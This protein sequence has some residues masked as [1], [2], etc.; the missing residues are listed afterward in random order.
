[1]SKG[2]PI[3]RRITSLA[4]IIPF[5]GTALVFGPIW[6]MTIPCLL[7]GVRSYYMPVL[8]PALNPTEMW[9]GTVLIVAGVVGTVAAHAC[10]HI[11]VASLT[12]A[13]LPRRL[14]LYPGGDAAHVWPEPTSA[15]AD[16]AST[17]AAIATNLAIAGIAY[18]IWARDLAALWNAVALFIL[19]VNAGMAT[20][21][22]SPAFP[23]DGGRLIRAL[24]YRSGADAR[25]GTRVALGLGWC[26]VVGLGVWAAFLY[27]QHL[28]FSTETGAI[29]LVV[30]LIMAIELGVEK[31]ARESLPPEREPAASRFSFSG[32]A[33]VTAAIVLLSPAQAILLPTNLGMQ[34]PGPA[35]SVEP[36]V[37]VPPDQFYASSGT[38]ILTTIVPQAPIVIGEWLYAQYDRGILIKPAKEIVRPDTS[39]Q[40]LA[41]QG[42]RDLEESEK[43]AI[44]VGLGLAGYQASLNY[45]GA[46][47][48]AVQPTSKANGVLRPGDDIVSV[49]GK[50]V[51][52]PS[53]VAQ[54]LSAN[55]GLAMADLEVRR[56]DQ[57]MA[58]SV[59][60]TPDADGTPRIGISI[61]AT[62][63]RLDLP[64][65]VSIT[66]RKIEGGPSAGLMFSLTVYNAVTP[67]DLTR[68][69]RIAGTGTIDANGEV[70]AIGGV[71]A[72]VAAA[73][74]AGAKY[75]LVPEANFEE[76]IAAS[77]HIEVV[78]V[79]TAADAIK[80]LQTL[81]LDS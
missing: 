34:A 78:P 32:L 29:T 52:A 4:L 63:D 27:L 10:A 47:I 22:L 57:D 45:T 28:R 60:L 25:T 30:M 20:L 24:V 17:L 15:K 19:L 1:M 11:V 18:L 54:I 66:P 61:V 33:L 67:D 55:P 56:G 50:P 36:M 38:F 42:F 43:T 72:K 53:D 16:A 76:A 40:Q 59:P 80:F 5:R 13:D 8:G 2:R 74:R 26:A 75:F 65:P 49:D 9:I 6:L 39:A 77:T 69:H 14:P 62:G 37:S 7:W 46:R 79:A 70:G 41:I 23:N 64:F 68:G 73:E 51:E 21:N 44:V 3:L 58:F 31:P 71:H 48:A 35:A 81:P 12:G